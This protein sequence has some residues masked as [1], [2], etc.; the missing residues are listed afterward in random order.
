[1]RRSLA[2]PAAVLLTA[3]ALS[4]AC[5]ST[6]TGRGA[7]APAQASE[8]L[9]FGVDMA[10]RG[11]WS[12]ALFRF[13]QAEKLEPGNPRIQNNLAVAYEATGEFE[14]ALQHYQSALKLDPNNRD[15]RANWTR[16]SQFYSAFTSQKRVEGQ[17][18][19]PRPAA[20][21]TA[22]GQQPEIPTPD[23]VRPAPRPVQPPTSDP[24]SPPADPSSP[25]VPL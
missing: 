13:H 9:D 2:V 15:L 8:Q 3:A 25:P 7:S 10:R 5:G 17:T 21:S 1:M 11:L 19:Q 14:Q 20:P 16:F 4:T 6:G 22:G 12:E 18:G 24:S 23:S